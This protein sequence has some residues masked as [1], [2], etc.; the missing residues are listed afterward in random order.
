M[1]PRFDAA[2]AD[3][4]E[5][6]AA[7]PADPVAGA[8]APVG[9]GHSAR[10][11]REDREDREDS[12]AQ[13]DRLAHAATARARRRGARQE[14][15][16]PWAGGLVALAGW[17]LVTAVLAPDGSM[18]AAFG[19]GDAWASLLRM[20]GDGS[21]LGNAAASVWRLFAGLALAVV[22]GVALG[23]AI[24]AQHLV[25]LA[26]RPV[27]LFLRMVSPLSWAPVAIGLFGVGD[28]PVIALVCATAVWPI[29]MSTADGVRRIDPGHLRVARLLGATRGERLRSVAWP[30]MQPGVLAGIRLAIGIGWVVLVPAEMLGVTSGLGYE[31]LNAKDQLAYSDIAALILVIGTLGYAIDAQ[32]RWLLRT[33]RERTAERGR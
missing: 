21:I 6:A 22:A 4:L 8:A 27:V 31:I 10:A 9:A 16:A 19:P 28:A 29:V 12:A 7:A 3:T 24:G 11:D 1:T 2:R 17:W 20:L 15:L 5:A 32:A 13:A 23:V 33:R 14:L 30:S 26:S 18:I 25:E